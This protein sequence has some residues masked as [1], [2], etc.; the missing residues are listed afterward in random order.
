MAKRTATANE[1]ADQACALI[2]RA[3]EA[4]ITE[5]RTGVAR[6]IEEQYLGAEDVSRATFSGLSADDSVVETLRDGG[7]AMA[8]PGLDG[9]AER[10][11]VE[12]V[13]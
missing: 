4:T 3:C 5:T 7:P 13:S 2:E 11:D 12:G 1:L 6:A 9:L 8:D 10:F